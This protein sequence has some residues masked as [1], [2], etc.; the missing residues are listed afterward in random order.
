LTIILIPAIKTYFSLELIFTLIFNQEMEI[1]HP[2]FD[3]M[4]YN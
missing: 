3:A 1:L 2:S 4:R